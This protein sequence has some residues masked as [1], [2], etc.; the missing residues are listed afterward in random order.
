MREVSALLE[1]GVL[2]AV[3]GALFVVVG[4]FLRAMSRKDEQNQR[5]I[6]KLLGDDREERT[7]QSKINAETTNKLSDAINDLTR[8]LRTR[9]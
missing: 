3:I 1:H 7:Q 2:G 8:E 9:D 6:E 4:W 5:F